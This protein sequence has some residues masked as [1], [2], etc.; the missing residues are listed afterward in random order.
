MGTENIK[1]NSR[2]NH[3]NAIKTSFHFMQVVH[4]SIL[5]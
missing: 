2:F 4:D 3:R 1:K 5:Y